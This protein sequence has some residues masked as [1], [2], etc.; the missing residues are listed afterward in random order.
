MLRCDESLSV[1]QIFVPDHNHH[2][3]CLRA[4]IWF[5]VDNAFGNYRDI[6][7]EV[8]YNRKCNGSFRS[9]LLF[10]RA[11]FSSYLLHDIHPCCNIVWL[12]CAALMGIYL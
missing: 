10:P 5:K 8:A 9:H 2:S 4:H 1:S 7:K 3:H 12:L 11:A 6:L